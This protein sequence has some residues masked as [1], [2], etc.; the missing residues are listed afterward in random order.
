MYCPTAANSDVK[1]AQENHQKLALAYLQKAKDICFNKGCVC[2]LSLQS[3]FAGDSRTVHRR[4]VSERILIDCSSK[5]QFQYADFGQARPQK[6]QKV[7]YR[8]CDQLLHST[9]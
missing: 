3:T 1:F 6:N 5:T 9:C 2:R 8:K 7:F 4:R